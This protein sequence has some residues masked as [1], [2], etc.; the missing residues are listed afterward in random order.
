MRQ[1]GTKL[2][3]HFYRKMAVCLLACCL[4]IIAAS[5]SPTTAWPNGKGAGNANIHTNPNG[6]LLG[7]EVFSPLQGGINPAGIIPG[8]GGIGVSGQA[9]GSG[10]SNGSLPNA[11]GSLSATNQT[12]FVMRTFKDKLLLSQPGSSIVIKIDSPTKGKSTSSKA[13]NESQSSDNK[14]VMAAGDVFSRA[15]AK[16]DLSSES[17]TNQNS[18]SNH[19]RHQKES[20][21]WRWRHRRREEHNRWRW[22]HRRRRHKGP[23]PDPCP[24]PDPDPEPDPEPEPEP[25]PLPEAVFVEPEEEGF[26]EGGCPALMEWLA[27]EL[28]IAEDTQ[29]IVANTFSHSTDIQPCNVTARLK[30]T[31][32]VLTDS[33]GIRTAALE[34]VINEFVTT[35]APLSEE[36]MALVSAALAEHRKDGTYYAAAGEWIAALA[37]YVS[38]LSTDLGYSLDDSTAVVMEKYGISITWTGNVPLA[39]FVQLQLSSPV[40]D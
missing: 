23:N 25:A 9:T 38:I 12:G 8:T 26:D 7:S 3:T 1:L 2:R 32:K 27:G 35:P 24:D 5:I 13:D 39:E 31:A 15:I 17:S 18:Y 10:M 21:R 19:H 22:R 28:G 6:M 40:E 14:F 20:N 34:R 30:N 4:I 36:Q 11:N 33:D 37:E 16:S 29:V